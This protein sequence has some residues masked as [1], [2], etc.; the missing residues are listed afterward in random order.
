VVVRSAIFLA[1]LLLALAGCSARRTQFQYLKHADA[2]LLIPPGVRD[3]ATDRRTFVFPTAARPGCVESQGGVDIRPHKGDLRVTV[4]R[5]PLFEQPPG[6]LMTWTASLEQRRCLAPGEGSALATR[7]AEALPSKQVAEQSLLHPSPAVSGYVDLGPGYKLRV[8]SPI[9][10]ESAAPGA[11]ALAVETVTG[12][13]HSINIDVKASDDLLGYETAWYTLEPR[14][15]SP[16]L[17]IVPGSAEARIGADVK[18]ETGPRTN[19]FA[20]APDEAYFR[21]FFLTRVSHADHDLAMLGAP[22]RA[23]LDEHTKQFEADP[24]LC[25]EK[26]SAKISGVACL[27]IPKEVGVLPHIVVHV[28]G[29][30]I[31]LVYGAVTVGGAIRQA[32][33][34]DP[35]STLPTLMVERPYGDRL[36]PVQFDRSSSDILGLLLVGGESIRWR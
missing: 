12:E 17:R 3:P 31:A 22:T 9:L 34:K 21:L 26:L 11:S 24:G 23:A 28:N 19:Y 35:Q 27:L 14:G 10:R 5:H 20:F 33:Q 4:E 1:L 18:P 13:G 25:A 30:E 8:V 15:G 6:W 32:G 16:G 36:V 2:A 7:I 29:C